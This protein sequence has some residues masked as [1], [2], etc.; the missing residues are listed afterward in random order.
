MFCKGFVVKCD[1][2]LDLIYNLKL[3]ICLIN[4]VMVDGKCGIAVN[5]IYNL[6]DIIKEFIGNDLLEV[7]E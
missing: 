3:V 4:C 6:F 1:V 2:L 7:F 5:I